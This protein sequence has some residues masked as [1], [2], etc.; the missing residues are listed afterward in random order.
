M[1]SAEFEREA[2]FSAA[3]AA[4]KSLLS[5]GV[6][7]VQEFE[8]IREMFVRKYRPLIGSLSPNSL[9]LSGE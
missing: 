3:L 2:R 5:R 9:D 8:K 1:T 4:A 6:I 7:T